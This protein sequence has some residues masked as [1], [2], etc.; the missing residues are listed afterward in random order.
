[1]QNYENQSFGDWLLECMGL[2]GIIA[3]RNLRNR[4]RESVQLVKEVNKYIKA[5]TERTRSG[6]AEP[7]PWGWH[8]DDDL[9][10][11]ELLRMAYG[12]VVESRVHQF[13]RDNYRERKFITLPFGTEATP[14][15]TNEWKVE[16]GAQKQ[17]LEEIPVG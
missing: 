17:V 16:Y 1:M 13:I 7:M 6:E 5:Y 15:P 12:T 11:N 3:K 2:R 14:H 9:F 8:D 4:Q 10:A